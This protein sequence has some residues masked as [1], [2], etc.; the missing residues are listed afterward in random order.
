MKL[1]L[2]GHP[3]AHSQSPRLYR[4]ILGSELE[5]YELIDCPTPESV[6]V[7][8]DLA[9]RLDGLNIT[10]PYKSHF[11][12]QIVVADPI[13]R[14]LGA[15]N[16]LSFA[17]GKVTGINT[18]VL[19]V[20]EILKNYQAKFGLLHLIILGS[21]V[22]AKV[23]ELVA[24][25]RGLSYKTLSRRTDGPLEELDLRLFRRPQ[26]QNIIVNCCSRGFVFKGRNSVEDV[27][28]DHNYSF[29]PHSESLPNF[30]KSYDDGRELLR[31]QAL[32]AVR[33]WKNKP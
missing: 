21:G 25:D 31:L 30:F 32:A 1:A 23:T 14:A 26:C 8:A 11:I 6:P 28:W 20:V 5:S 18:D 2:I 33:F 9:K 27:F 10:S 24:R 17:D 12:D 3:V 7:L 19:A 13:A 29:P 4:E 22:M 16:T 15:V